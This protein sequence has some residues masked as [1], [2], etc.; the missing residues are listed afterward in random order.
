MRGAQQAV[1]APRER[2]E[3]ANETVA[4]PF[5]ITSLD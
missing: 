4:P 2:I 3:R 1:Y 5:E